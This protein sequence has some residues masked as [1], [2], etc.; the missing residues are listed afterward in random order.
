MVTIEGIGFLKQG[1]S[2]TSLLLQMSNSSTRGSVRRT[3]GNPS[4]QEETSSDDGNLIPKAKQRCKRIVKQSKRVLR[5]VDKITATY[6]NEVETT[7]AQMERNESEIARLKSENAGLKSEITELKSENTGLKSEITK[8]KSEVS[9]LGNEMATQINRRCEALLSQKL[10]EI[11]RKF[12][13]ALQT[14]FQDARR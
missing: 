10:D 11:D 4:R 5:S 1:Q 9:R 12:M 14:A 3:R 2:A 7:N 6:S 8:L 13:T